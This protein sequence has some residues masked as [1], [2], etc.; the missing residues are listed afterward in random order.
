MDNLESQQ[1]DLH[2]S[3]KLQTKTYEICK[4]FF[5]PNLSHPIPSHLLFGLENSPFQLVLTSVG[6]FKENLSGPGFDS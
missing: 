4:T 6:Q 1:L 2:T 3:Q 5:E